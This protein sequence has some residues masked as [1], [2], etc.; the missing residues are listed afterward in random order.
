MLKLHFAK[1]V[2]HLIGTFRNILRIIL[3]ENKGVHYPAILQVD[4]STCVKGNIGIMG[5]QKD[6]RSLPVYLFDY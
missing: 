1:P 4:Y 6:S 2:L 5:Y 3:S